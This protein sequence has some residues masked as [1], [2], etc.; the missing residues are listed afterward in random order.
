MPATIRDVAKAAGVTVGTVSRALNNYSDVNFHTRER[1][2][3]IAQEL[4][5]RPNQLARSLSSKHMKNIALIL[6]GFLEDTMFNDFETMLMKGIYQ[7]TSERDIDISMYVINSKIQKEKTYEQL[8]YEHNIAGAIL[9]GLK[10]TDPYCQA[11]AISQRPCVTIDTEVQGPYTSNVALDDVAAFDALAQYLIDRGHRKIVLIHG[12]KTAMVSMERLAGA[13]QA[14][15]RNGITLT[16]DNIIYTNF[17]RE[18]AVAGVEAYFK[19]HAPDSVTAFLCMSDMLAVGAIEA[20]KALGY[21]VPQDYSVVGYDGLELTNYTD[22]KITTVDQ[23]I[24]QKGY[25][26]ARLLW[27]M[28]NG[29]RTAQKLVLPHTLVERESV[30]TL[31]QKESG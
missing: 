15:A 16:H 17:F 31:N 5:Y 21:R 27:D 14:F 19:T 24:K 8:C 1:I 2:R 25:E 6:S 3:R 11:L 29:V 7:F 30:R 26:A 22:P 23:N 13:Y 20:L 4:G 12:R 18:E 9:F 28:L 10:T